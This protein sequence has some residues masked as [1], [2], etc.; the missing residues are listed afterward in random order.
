MYSHVRPGSRLCLPLLAGLAL[1]LATPS[2]GHR[3]ASP[4]PPAPAAAPPPRPP[5]PARPKTLPPIAFPDLDTGQ[6]S[7]VQF[8]PDGR[9]LAFGYGA[10]AEVTVWNLKTGRL[11]WQRHVDGADGG[12]ILIDPKNRFYV[13]ET[14]DMD[15]G[16][17]FVACTPEGELLRKLVSPSQN[18]DDWE[19]NPL[20]WLNK[21][22][23]ILVLTSQYMTQ[24]GNGSHKTPT[25]RDVY[26][27]RSWRRLSRTMTGS[28]LLPLAASSGQAISGGTVIAPSHLVS[29]EGIPT[30]HWWKADRLSSVGNEYA[31]AWRNYYACAG[32]NG[33]SK[34][35]IEVWDLQRRKRLWTV[36]VKNESPRSVAISPDGQSLAVGSMQGRVS[37]WTLRTGRRLASARCSGDVIRCL[38]YSPNGRVLA[39]AGDEYGGGNGVRLLDARNGKTLAVLK[40]AFPENGQEEKDWTLDHPD[41]F[42]ALPDLSYLASDGMEKKI[43]MPGRARDAGVIGRFRRVRAALAACYH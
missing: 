24:L 26:E 27:T 2:C 32:G 31:A 20:A 38:A 30:G 14:G 13:V 15:N 29:V 8:S 40:A 34:G 43:R 37:F 12:P 10:D 18:T 39:A 4:R 28:P 9:R 33:V 25:Q 1:I 41:W 7:D 21:S 42:A 6:I 36:P 23:R 5:K 22:G 35:D 16:T 3:A 19:E 11:D 17:H